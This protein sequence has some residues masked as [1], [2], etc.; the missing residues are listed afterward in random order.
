MTLFRNYNLKYIIQVAISD[1]ILA[2]F[3]YCDHRNFDSSPK[4]SN[5]PAIFISVTEDIK[6]SIRHQIVMVQRRIQGLLL[7]NRELYEIIYMIHVIVE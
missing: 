3:L 1:I 5:V 4:S 7:N 6:N 2:K